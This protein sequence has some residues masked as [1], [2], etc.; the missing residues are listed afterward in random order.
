MPT[1]SASAGPAAMSG[2]GLPL[3]QQADGATPLLQPSR[4]AT[5]PGGIVSSALPPRA[6]GGFPSLAHTVLGR[7]STVADLGA[8]AVTRRGSATTDLASR[9]SERRR[10]STTRL[11]FMCAICHEVMSAP[12]VTRCGHRFDQHCLAHWL[13]LPR[14]Q[15]E[16][17]G[18]PRNFGPCPL[19]KKALPRQALPIDTRLQAHIFAYFPD[20]KL[21]ADRHGF[22]ELS[23]MAG[24]TS[25][26]RRMILRCPTRPSKP[27]EIKAHAFTASED[28]TVRVWSLPSGECMAVL[29]GHDSWVCCLAASDD[30][31]VLA[32]GGGD[33]E[34][35][36]W[37]TGIVSDSSKSRV[38]SC[39][40]VC[41]G[42][43]GWV[44]SLAMQSGGGNDGVLLSGGADHTLRLWG[45]H[46]GL[47]RA[48][49]TGASRGNL[50]VALWLPPAVVAEPDASST[51]TASSRHGGV[52][53]GGGRALHLC[54]WELPPALTVLH[55]RKRSQCETLTGQ[56]TTVE[57]ARSK[58]LGHSK[59]CLCMALD[60][61][62]HWLAAGFADGMVRLFDCSPNPD[63]HSVAAENSS[64]AEEERMMSLKRFQQR[65]RGQGAP[66]PCFGA[67]Q[68][69]DGAVQA[70]A[71]WERIDNRS[72]NRAGIAGVAAGFQGLIVSGARDG[73][74][75][76]WDPM[77]GGQACMFSLRGHRS[78]IN[79]LSL[80]SGGGAR[81]A[82]GSDDGSAKV[83]SLHDQACLATV[84][85]PGRGYIT[86]VQLTGQLL[87]L[88]G[89]DKRG[90]VVWVNA[91]ENED[92][93]RGGA[94]PM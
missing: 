93:L 85:P 74:L 30:G 47:C 37:G 25:R 15:M 57:I 83:W 24:H 9:L 7:P 90:H 32:S 23:V 54:S 35:R 50:G 26:V 60:S 39:R 14:H 1:M 82:S 59:V 67:L 17:S 33:H 20:A 22:K 8:T 48:V 68:G 87:V 16:G 78:A 71:W 49:L 18:S 64:S 65:Q 34:I 5:T 43:E 41:V 91:D 6:S 73:L 56:L 75:R 36:I 4:R 89:A 38:A 58:Q 84:R 81:V 52:A 63:A 10:S 19:C 40:H 62:G 28:G 79:C 69:H 94:A 61:V 13:R 2:G 31:T 70:I 80:C 45:L 21:R 55:G 11:E 12:V 29:E 72:A 53:I 27:D 46:D 77:P 3:L 86:Q 88:A 76:V 66:D 51:P 44:L 42:H 92:G